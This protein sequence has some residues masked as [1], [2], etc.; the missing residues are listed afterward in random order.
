[1]ASAVRMVSARWAG[2]IETI[3]DLGG[4]TLFLEADGFFDGDLVRRGSWTS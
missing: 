2:P 3:D 4:D 1:M